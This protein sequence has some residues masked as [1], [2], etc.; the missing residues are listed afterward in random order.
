MPGIRQELYLIAD[1]MR[2]MA[3]LSQR[4]AANVYE[5]ERAQRM[6][7]LATKIAVLADDGSPDDVRAIFDAEPWLRI[8]PAIGV[9]AAVFDASGAILL[10]QRRDSELWVLPGGVAEIGET[11][12]ESAL[13]ELW[14]ESGLEGSVARLLAV[15]DGRYW[16]T[17][18]K[19][20]LIHPVFFVECLDPDPV[21]GIEM[22]DARFFAPDQLPPL[23]TGHDLRVPK[24]IELA[25]NGETF[26]DPATSA[27]IELAVHQRPADEHD[28]EQGT[29]S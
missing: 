22:L 1:E 27:D 20:H 5:R 19:V 14:E 10:V 6:M 16:G 15:F 26:F 29:E 8:S 4:F 3:S 28:E 17:R 24:V 2:G 21:P 23:H 7:E 9:E 13:R 12:A 18:G 11:L 25:R